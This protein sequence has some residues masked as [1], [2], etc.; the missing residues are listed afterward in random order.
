MT[1]KIYIL[2]AGIGLSCALGVAANAANLHLPLS[3]QSAVTLT[4]SNDGAG[5]PG[6]PG[7]K[8]GKPGFTIDGVRSL[9]GAD[10]DIAKLH[11]Y[12]AKVMDGVEAGDRKLD[13][14]EE[15]IPSDCVDFFV[16]PHEEAHADRPAKS[17]AI[18]YDED[19]FSY[20]VDLLRQARRDEALPGY[21]GKRRVYSGEFG[22]R[23]CADYF[24]SLEPS[25]KGPGYHGL[26]RDGS[27]GASVSGGVGGAGGRAGR[28]A[29][30]G[31]GGDGGDGVAG[32][33]GGKGGKGGT[34][35]D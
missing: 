8:G 9:A 32:G 14:T 25:R 31:S 2:A 5:L 19:L 11:K 33:V 23:D 26:K 7:G 6:A 35:S 4:G 34:A 3:S 27:R 16:V 12:C 29:G 17:G 20:C 15:F 10:Y 30:G 28:G 22:P 13:G 24:A 21:K 18:D 1:R